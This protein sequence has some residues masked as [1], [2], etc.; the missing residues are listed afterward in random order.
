VTDPTNNTPDDDPT[1]IPNYH[2]YPR[3]TVFSHPDPF[4]VITDPYRGGP[5]IPGWVIHN[6]GGVD[7]DGLL[8]N[9]DDVPTVM[10]GPHDG[11]TGGA[12]RDRLLHWATGTIH[13]ANPDVAV[14]DWAW[15]WGDGDQAQGAPYLFEASEATPPSAVAVPTLVALRHKITY[16]M[17]GG[18]ML[19]FTA[20]GRV[21][22]RRYASDVTRERLHH[23]D[24]TPDNLHITGADPH[25]EEGYID[26]DH[27][28]A[29]FHT[30][31]RLPEA[32]H[33]PGA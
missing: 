32:P 29:A 31:E 10:G 7:Y 20:P 13:Q 26:L 11:E 9:H 3:Y 17:V 4:D 19:T 27:V 15:Y 14:T 22:V 18:T 16:L 28:A 23:W 24:S 5:P 2:R 33:D 1:I 12:F 21:V 25:A 30:V 6:P 8:L